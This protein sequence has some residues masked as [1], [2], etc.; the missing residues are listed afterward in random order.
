MDMKKARDL[1]RKENKAKKKN[2]KGKA[3]AAKASA[4]DGV[5]SAGDKPAK[6]PL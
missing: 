4:I 2:D 3:K 1:A 6:K 5:V